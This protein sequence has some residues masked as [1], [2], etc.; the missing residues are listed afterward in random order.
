[1]L[2]YSE[3]EEYKEQFDLYSHTE[4]IS[5]QTVPAAYYTALSQNIYPK[6]RNINFILQA[7]NQSTLKTTKIITSQQMPI[8][9]KKS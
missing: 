3:A 1:M 4:A 2:L 8:V 9:K 5:A 7:R 6:Q